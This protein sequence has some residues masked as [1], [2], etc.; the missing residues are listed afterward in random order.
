MNKVWLSLLSVAVIFSMGFSSGV[1]KMAGAID[2]PGSANFAPVP[3]PDGGVLYFTSDRNTG[4]GGQDIW[5]SH[6]VNGIWSEPVDLSLPLNGPG[7]EGA[8]A[9][10]YDRQNLYMFL[11][12]CNQADGQGGCDLYLSVYNPE[13][14]WTEAQ[15]LGPEINTGYQEANAFFDSRNKILYFISNRPAGFGPDTQQGQ[16]TYDFW[17]SFQLPDGK[18]SEP[19]NLGAPINT[20]ENEH[21]IYYDAATGWFFFSSRGHRGRGGTDIFK[22]K[23]SSLDQWG[24]IIPVEAVNSEGND[25]YFTLSEGGDYAFFDSDVEGKDKIYM[26][27]VTEIFSPEEI[28]LREQYYQDNCPP[29]MPAVGELAKALK[30]KP[31]GSPEPTAAPSATSAEAAALFTAAAPLEAAPRSSA[32][33][34]ASSKPTVSAQAGATRP[35]AAAPP[36][37]TP[38]PAAAASST[39][40]QPLSQAAAAT[41]PAA[42]APA[43]AATPEPAATMPAAAPSPPVRPPAAETPSA[44][45]AASRAAAPAKAAESAVRVQTEMPNKIYF[46]LDKAGV[47][48]RAVQTLAAWAD[49]LKQNPQRKVEISGHADSLGRADYNLLLSKRRV[50]SVAAWLVRAGVRRE[51]ILPAYYGS[52]RP[53]EPNDPVKGSPGNR[54]VEFRVMD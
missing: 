10:S 40:P 45:A 20:A 33:A 42:A 25:S 47:N 15:N 27:P 29:A 37:A 43:P 19:K 22:V 3:S 53:T 26:V 2:D 18:W 38:E 21:K 4:L 24:D 46:G 35:V 51:Q 31:C 16:L 7:N 5:V 44:V 41:P 8:D 11:T 6:M 49:Y 13:G 30:M 17:Y 28:S 48:A 23:L 32:A 50:D 1:I 39:A 36:A 34:P 9:F 54:R 12:L 52:T 14:S